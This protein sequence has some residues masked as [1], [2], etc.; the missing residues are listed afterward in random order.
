MYGMVLLALLIPPPV[1]HVAVPPRPCGV[2]LSSARHGPGDREAVDGRRAGAAPA[3]AGAA[4]PKL[5]ASE[6][7]AVVVRVYDNSRLRPTVGNDAREVA[8]GILETAGLRVVWAECGGRANPHAVADP[9][10]QTLP[11]G[12]LIVRLQTSGR[13]IAGDVLGFSYVPGV[14]ATALTDRVE[15]AARRAR[16]PV[17]RLLG[18]VI[19]HEIGH[20]FLGSSH[21]GHGLMQGV[22]RDRDIRSAGR[23]LFTVGRMERPAL[24]VAGV[25]PAPGADRT[26]G[27][28]DAAAV[29]VS[30]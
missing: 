18:A 6:S 10:G 23:A 3:V 26:P 2:V 8:S 11:S 14:V 5:P 15:E 22:W 7:N 25:Q 9:C 21:T 27:G 13:L 20:L 24:G 1:A 19:A 28:L 29:S 12:D 17:S 30:E 16:V 4:C